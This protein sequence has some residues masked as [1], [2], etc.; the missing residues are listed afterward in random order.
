MGAAHGLGD[1]LVDD[2]EPLE[3][4]RRHLHRFG[5]ILGVGVV[6][7]QDRGATLR[8][9]H[10]V[11]RVLQHVDAVGGGDGQCAARAAFADHHA[12][13]WHTERQAGVDRTRHRLGLA[14][15][16]GV[17]AGIGARGVDQGDHRYA[18]AVGELHQALRLAVALGPGHA[19]IVLD[20]GVG[21]VALLL[22]EHD[23]AA[24]LEAA[25]AAHDRGV[26][27]EGAV[28][29]Q[30]HVVGDQPVDVA[31]GMRAFRMPRNLHALP[32]RQLGIGRAKLPLHLVLEAHHLLGDVDI[33]RV[34]QVP[35]LGDLAFEL[36]DRLLE[37]EIGRH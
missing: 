37:V 14:A 24:A 3:V 12:H 5:G 30:R 22:A 10:R 35:E 36:R 8:R 28:T 6:A 21:I 17:D 4:A 29:G 25:H 33:A 34:G 32:R 1:H 11:D 7:P 2:L 26:F 18:E 23:H 31:L 19:E 13:Q 9:D 27:A 16:F 15:R 20:A